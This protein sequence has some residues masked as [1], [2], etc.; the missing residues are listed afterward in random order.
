MALNYAHLLSH[1]Y[2]NCGQGGHQS[3]QLMHVCI[4]G[5]LS[6]WSTI[7]HSYNC[8]MYNDILWLRLLTEQLHASILKINECALTL[9][10]CLFQDFLTR[11]ETPNAKIQGKGSKHKSKGSN[12]ISKV[13]N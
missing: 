7:L 12:H 3:T 1:H 13:G 11:G 10:Q 8:I 2:R 4:K 6:L 9:V 5:E